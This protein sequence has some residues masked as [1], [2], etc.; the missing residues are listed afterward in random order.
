M[1]KIKPRFTLSE[2]EQLANSD[3]Q[4][5]I[6]QYS[7]IVEAIATSTQKADI[8]LTGSASYLLAKALFTQHKLEEAKKVTMKNIPLAL[9]H[10]DYNVLIKHYLLLAKCFYHTEEQHRIKACFEIAMGYARQ[11]IEPDLLSKV[12]LDYG[13]YLTNI[14]AF[15][16]ALSS[17]DLACKTIVQSQNLQL[18][19]D[20]LLAMGDVYY[21]QGNHKKAL[22]IIS[23]AYDLS[24][25]IGDKPAQI[26]ILDQLATLYA[27]TKRFDAAAK[28]IEKALEACKSV[29]AMRFKILYNSGTL[30]LRQ[31]WGAE[32]LELFLTAESEAHHAGYRLPRFFCE[33]NSNIAGCYWSMNDLE[34]TREHLAKAISIVESLNNPEL[35]I[36]TKLNQSHSMI[37]MKD[38]DQAKQVINDA[39]SFYTNANNLPQLLVAN[40]AMVYLHEYS[41]DLNAA[42]SAARNNESIYQKVIDSLRAELSS[43]AEHDIAAIHWK[44]PVITSNPLATNSS[45]CFVGNSLASRRVLES[46]LLAAQHPNANVF[47]YG[48]SGTGKDV[49]ANII[50][51]NSIRR[52]SP[53][54]A[55]NMAA[56]ST[57]ILESEL[58][59]HLRGAFTG[60]T[61]PKKGLLLKANHGTLFMDEI[62]EIPYDLQAK[63]LRVVETGRFTPVGSNEEVGY[64]SRIICTSNRDIYQAIRLNTFRL[65]LFHRLNTIEIFIPPLRERKE[66]IDDLLI[67]YTEV[68]A[69]QNKLRIPKISEGF[70]NI[71]KHYP[72]P[73]NVRELKNLVER[74]FILKGSDSWT[75]SDLIDL[76]IVQRSSSPNPVTW[77]NPEVE[78]IIRALEQAEGKQK[79]AARILGMS[80]STLCRRIVKYRLEAYTIRHRV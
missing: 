3:P 41:G 68:Y 14:H 65:D 9:K 13:T 55:I 49:L 57:G 28:M 75:E 19:T 1:N 56:L 42:L 15:K 64:D 47:L 53:F 18:Q 66:D 63:L 26:A 69:H 79:D 70:L 54:I 36:Q 39:I 46:A 44:H 11:A 52:D 37:L 10:Q 20:V 33:L 67:Y 45:F 30:K 61:S 17:L 48:E 62:T 4:G 71:L 40:R 5:F 60:A 35:L 76:N 22:K 25:T 51:N 21:Q 12:C 78:K 59:G 27:L 16:S 32:A 74:L 29:P 73:G 24:L 2:L 34:K 8:H 43:E 6:S 58:F 50:H 80:E 23:K 77:S 38:F 7:T 72:F 31:G